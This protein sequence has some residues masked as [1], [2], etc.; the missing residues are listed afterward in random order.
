MLTMNIQLRKIEFVRDFLKIEDEELLAL[1]EQ[2]LYSAKLDAENNIQSMS[3]E[4]LNQRIDKSMEDA[5]KGKLT[6]SSDL[7]SEIQKWK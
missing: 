3:V 2:L 4:E 5:Q 1:L 7:I 6:K